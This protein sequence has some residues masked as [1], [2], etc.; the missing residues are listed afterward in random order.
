VAG[1]V[2][3]NINLRFD[4]GHLKQTS[5][6]LILRKEDSMKKDIVTKSGMRYPHIIHSG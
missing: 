2:L 4:S 3:I 6:L 5:E 1:K